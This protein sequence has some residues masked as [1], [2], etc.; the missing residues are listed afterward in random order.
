M[1]IGKA[2]AHVQ[3]RRGHRIRVPTLQDA[4]HLR[5]MPG[6]AGIHEFAAPQSKKSWMAGTSPAM[7]AERS[8]R[9]VSAQSC[10]E[11]TC[12]AVGEA[13][14]EGS[15][16]QADAARPPGCRIAEGE[17]R[18]TP[19]ASHHLQTLPFNIALAALR[20]TIGRFR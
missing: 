11:T 1:G 16:K 13:V 18:P 12:G 14:C 10:A 20:R 15:P 3:R 8:R 17:G 7:T 2:D 19:T 5:V 9:N 6:L 4:L